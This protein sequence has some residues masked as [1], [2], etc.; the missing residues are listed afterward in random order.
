MRVLKNYR[1]SIILLTSMVAGAVLG[2]FIGPKAEVLQPFATI[3][4][5][6]LYVC[7]VPL[8][9]TSLVSAISNMKSTKRLGKILGIMFTLFIV[10][11]ILAAIYMLIVTMIF[12][13]S[14]GV[15]LDMTQKI[16]A[17][18]ANI[19]ILSML[20]VNDFPLLWSRQ[21]LMALIVF[22]IIFGIALS[23]L[24]EKTAKVTEVID[25]LSKVII[26]IVGYVMLLAPLGLGSFFAVLIG[27][28]GSEIVGPLSRAIIIFFIASVVYY[29]A[30]SVI[31]AFIG[32]GREGIRSFFKYIIPPTLTSLGTCSS[33][34]A[35][36]T[37]LIAGEKI[38]LSEEI[39]S[40]TI[41][42][43]ANLHKDGAVLIQILKIVFMSS[44]FGVDM[45]NPKNI[46][47]A[48]A[49]SVLASCVMGAIPA[50]GY[51][52]EIFIVSAFGFPE[53]SIPIMILIGTITDAPAT[54]INATGDV[55]VGMMLSRI[56]DGKGWI[57]KAEDVAVTEVSEVEAPALQ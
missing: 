25:Q 13:P 8:I 36:P 2:G 11:G 47:I 51:T 7:I 9:F 43:G 53:V 26:K 23:S 6:L 52:G 14:K 18:K 20:T 3:F 15:V 34:A 55:G 16:D 17:G 5:N 57:K 41:P 37:N 4:L 33:A 24:G 39:N 28:Q 50:G 38:G 1:S 27:Q 12:D 29:F 10:T 45:S 49:V 35:I 32:A 42:L 31:M 48:I 21:S 54:A 22:T 44:V 56:I 30:S 40:L 19:D 46:I